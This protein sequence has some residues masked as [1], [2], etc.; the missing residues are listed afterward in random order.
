MASW[1]VNNCGAEMV[2]R[3]RSQAMS[4]SPC[5]LVISV[6]INCVDRGNL[7]I[8]APLLKKPI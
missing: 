1:R 8:A 7:S 5:T 2:P 4:V 6:F 3:T